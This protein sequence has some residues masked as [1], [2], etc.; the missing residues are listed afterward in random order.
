MGWD[1]MRTPGGK[2][3]SPGSRHAIKWTLVLVKN[4]ASE[5]LSTLATFQPRSGRIQ[6]HAVK[7]TVRTTV[8]LTSSGASTLQRTT[9]LRLHRVVL[10][11]VVGGFSRGL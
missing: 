3:G 1:L 5:K 7:L 9:P 6:N 11:S 2:R 8:S 4:T 10:L